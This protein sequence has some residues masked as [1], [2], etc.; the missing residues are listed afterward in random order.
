MAN[1]HDCVQRAVDAKELD[2]VRGAAV[3]SEF[4]QL[5]ERYIQAMPRHQ[6]EA[7]ALA[8]VKEAT[9]RAAR[10]RQH[11]VLNQLQSMTRIKHLIEGAD[12]P[13]I[14]LRNLLEKSETGGFKGESVQ[15]VSEA[16]IKSVNAG[17]NDVL[18]GVG[19]N[20][21]GN[22]RNAVLLRDILRELH[23]QDSGVARARVMADAVR[24]QQRRMRQMF[25]AHGGDIGELADFGVSHSHDVAQLRQAGFSKWADEITPLL[26]WSRIHNHKTGKPFS[27]KGETPSDE[28]VQ[29]FLNDVYEGITSRG[30]DTREPSLSVGGKA[31][32]NRRADHRILHFNDGDAW[33]DY[34]KSFG[35]SDPFS[36]MIGGL[37]GMAREVAQMRVLGPNPKMGL[38]YATQVAQKQAAVTKNANL[39]V[40][41][42]KQ[43]G[44]AR[45]MLAHIDGSVNNTD[46]EAWARFFS[47]TRKV[48]TSI[49]LGSALMSSVTDIATISAA[50]KVMGMAPNNVLSRSV[51]LMSSHATRETAARMGYV[52][53]TLADAGST[54]ARF[55]G[56]VVAGEFAERVSGFTMRAS[57][58]SFWTDMNKIA[59][60]MEMAGFMA[61]NA[62][63]QFDEIDAPL[64]KLFE[65]R[66]ISPAD[67]DYLRTPDAMF[68]A[69]NGATFIAPFHWL[70]HQTSLPRAEA[71]GLAMRLQ[72]AIEEQLERAI[73]TA[74][75]EGR[76]RMLGDTAPGTIAG[77]IAR[78]TAMYKSFSVSLMLNQYRRFVSIPTPI[79][80][81]KYAAGVSG[82]LLV[83]GAL[84]VQLKEMVKGNDPR[85]MDNWTFFKAALLQG[86]GIGIFGDFFAAEMSRTG[87]GV[88]EAAMGPVL[89]FAGAV[90]KPFAANF[91]SII[92][93]K[94]THFG[95]DISTFVRRNTP[96][97]S[98]LW[99]TR[100]AYDRIVAD[101]LQSF[102]DPDAEAQW[103]RQMRQRERDY[104]TSTWWDRG[105]AT[106]SRA[107]DL[108]NVIGG[109]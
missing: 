13:A 19:R 87:G 97:A 45:T 86:G 14:A 51:K 64:R 44:L 106:P 104:G 12:D 24:K 1:L 46:A 72:M 84:A 38:E 28:T 34:N 77:E 74:T 27:K 32:Y 10:S 98:S 82:G 5:V 76:A 60:Q 89:G 65:D 73:P 78:S 55:T 18:R 79:G 16:M 71:E 47:N 53:D 107:P 25:N 39:E 20:V 66:G 2:P 61:E 83:L 99:P 59:F 3:Q 42:K 23:G 49:Q 62:M 40:R 94:S 67:W 8:H 100:V 93:G 103:R 31:L 7:T 29:T 41:I 50:S 109:K 75:I 57:G 68:R 54:S 4:N 33:L 63:R 92:D 36:A 90:I 30:W 81:A 37:H 52:A 105:A 85:P 101:T 48:L 35:T 58:L 11:M 80:K 102:L 22:S 91:G 15:S 21:I 96:V 88:G 70:E 95:R 43:A 6:A 56:D 26:D 69:D 9:S 17:L 108:T